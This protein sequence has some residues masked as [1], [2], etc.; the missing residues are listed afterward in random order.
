L[1][2]TKHKL[3]RKEKEDSLKIYK[4]QNKEIKLGHH[5]SCKN[6]AKKLQP[7]NKIKYK[8]KKKVL[9]K[10]KLQLSMYVPDLTQKAET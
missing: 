6:N 1:N 3:K 2:Q 10:T 9:Q 7:C 4:R 5:K 8:S